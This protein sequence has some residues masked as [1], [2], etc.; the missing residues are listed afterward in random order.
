MPNGSDAVVSD[1]EVLRVGAGRRAHV[2]DV[3]YDLRIGNGVPD[4]RERSGS[5]KAN[6]AKQQQNDQAHDNADF[7]DT[8]VI[9]ARASSINAAGRH[10]PLRMPA[11][12]SD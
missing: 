8:Q 10:S 2:H 4:Q 1:V 9:E 12:A 7:H 5:F 11:R 6:G 3:A